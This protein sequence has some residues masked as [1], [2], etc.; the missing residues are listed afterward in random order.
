MQIAAIFYRTK[1]GL[2]DYYFSFEQLA[3]GNWRAFILSQPSYGGRSE[4]LH[5]THRLRDGGRYYVCWTAPL[6]TFH[7]TQQVAAIWADSTQ[8]YIRTGNS[9]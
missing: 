7:D 4:S 8:D 6:S 3:D 5:D 1:D 2:A 9:F